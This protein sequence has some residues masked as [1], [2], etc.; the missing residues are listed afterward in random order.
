[1]GN[2]GSQVVRVA[3]H[4]GP[5]SCPPERGVQC[6][7]GRDVITCWSLQCRAALSAAWDV[8]M[9][10]ADSSHSATQGESAVRINE[11]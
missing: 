10:Q 7:A 5:D 8:F 4:T 2:S 1:M 11:N 3:G 9:K 6:R